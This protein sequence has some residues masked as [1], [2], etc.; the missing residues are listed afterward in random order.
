MCAVLQSI[1]ML[2]SD[3]NIFLFILI[4]FYLCAHGHIIEIHQATSMEYNYCLNQEKFRKLLLCVQMITGVGLW[5]VIYP[6]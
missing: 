1:T 4:L 6:F 2:S 5:I 3:E